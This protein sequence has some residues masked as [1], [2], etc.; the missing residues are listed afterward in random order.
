MIVRTP[1]R[2]AAVLALLLAVAPAVAQDPRPEVV[3]PPENVRYDYAQVLGVKPIYQVLRTSAVER[4]CRSTRTIPV[5]FTV[6]AATS[7]VAAR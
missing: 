1:I 4:G 7:C 2:P 3:I 5:P 6:S